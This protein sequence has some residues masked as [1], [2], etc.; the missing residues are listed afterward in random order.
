MLDLAATAHDSAPGSGLRVPAMVLTTLVPNSGIQF[1]DFSAGDEI[2]AHTRRRFFEDRSSDPSQGPSLHVASIADGVFYH[3]ITNQPCHPAQTY[4][5]NGVEAMAAFAGAWV[6]L[7]FMRIAGR[8]G[9]LDLG[10]DEGPSNWVRA[11]VAPDDGASGGYHVVL[12]VDTT[13]DAGPGQHN[14]GYAAPSIDDLRSGA[15]FRFSDDVADVAWFATEAWVDDW[16]SQAF[17][18]S[19]RSRSQTPDD[20]AEPGALEH[21]AHYLTLLAVLKEACHLPALRFMEPNAV[22]AYADTVAVDL[23]LDIGTARTCA[24]LR[25]RH[26]ARE[27]TRLAGAASGAHLS[28]GTNALET[29]ELTVRDLSRPWQTT[30]GLFSSRMEF[31]RASFGNDALS[32]WSGR[33]HAFHWPS[34]VRIGPE[35]EM[36]AREASSADSCTGVS[37]PLHYVWDEAART[38][39]WRF[40][41]KVQAATR[42]NP[43]VA[44]PA[45]AHLTESGDVIDGRDS[46]SATTK[47]RFSRSALTTFFVAELLLQTVCTINSTAH[48]QRS[49]RP[50]TARRLDRVLVTVPAGMP[51]AELN[52]LRRRIEAAVRLVWKVMGWSAAAEPVALAPAEPTVVL[53]ADTATSTQIAF[54]RNEITHKFRGKA[55]SYFALMGRQ[56]AGFAGAR[57]LRLATLDIGA[58]ST[59]LAVTTYDLGASGT[60]SATRQFVDGF[61]IGHGDVVKAIGERVIVPAIEQ[62]LVDCKLGNARRFIEALVGGAERGAPAWIGDLGRRFT[63]EMVVP[64]A[65]ALVRLLEQP[66]PGGGEATHELSLRTLLAGAVPETRLRHDR[67]E[68]R[69]ML[70]ARSVAERLDVLAADEGADGFSPLD[71]LVPFLHRELAQHARTVLAPMLDSALRVIEALDCDGVLLTG[72]G[73]R[74]PQVLEAMLESIPVRPDRIIVLADYRMG[75]WYRYADATGRVLDPKRMAA[76]GALLQGGTAFGRSGPELV[77]QPLDRTRART[78]IGRLDASGLLPGDAVLFTTGEDTSERSRTLSVELPVLFGVRQT[79]LENWPAQPLYSLELVAHQAARRP[80]MPLK[81]TVEQLAPDRGQPVQLKLVSAFD[82]DGNRLDASEIGLRLKTRRFAGGHWLDTGR[83][84]T[85]SARSWP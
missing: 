82:A 4:T 83:L 45:L 78:F 62:R 77:V 2:V 48:R 25:E 85:T 44:G 21:L 5:I 55:E 73:A 32:R 30:A 33:P 68:A 16:L 19:H 13:I 51:E 81:V 18:A 12:A 66:A 15:S 76:I 54:L 27:R 56:R 72:C 17:R 46:R 36:L 61:D 20:A 42:R 63:V 69:P 70:D 39:V 59:G 24:L 43:I 58:A 28:A 6:P 35:A 3:P 10:L 79:S 7:P 80:R 34:L 9:A 65:G 23:A 38:D 52:I 53:V 47:P 29:S 57:T 67:P 75:P 74:L 26:Q 1:I 64:A 14:R 50:G 31:A 40:A 11:F 60:L 84:E 49:P 41:G 22:G 8:D 71:T 37:S